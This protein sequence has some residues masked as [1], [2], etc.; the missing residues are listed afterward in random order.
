M[1]LAVPMQ[2][3]RLNGFDAR[4]S[5]RGVDRDVSLFLLQGENLS[6]GDYVLI[7]VGYAIQKLSAEDAA[8]TWEL[9]DQILDEEPQLHA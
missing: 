5:A 7:H 4:C 3:T 1:C 9:F 8:S 2:I 6:I